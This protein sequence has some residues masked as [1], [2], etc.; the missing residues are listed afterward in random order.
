MERPGKPSK[1]GIGENKR[2][3]NHIW[4]PNRE[5]NRIHRNDSASLSL[6]AKCFLT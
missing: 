4:H 3:S 5:S 1:Q 2:N 6:Q